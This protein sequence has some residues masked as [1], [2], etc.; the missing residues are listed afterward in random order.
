MVRGERQGTLLGRGRGH[1]PSPAQLLRAPRLGGARPRAPR[2]LQGQA[3]HQRSPK[4]LLSLSPGLSQ[5]SD[6]GK[7]QLQPARPP[8]PFCHRL[9]AA[10]SPAGLGAEAAASQAGPGLQHCPSGC[11]VAQ[12]GTR[13]CR[14]AAG[15]S[16]TRSQPRRA[17]SWEHGVRLRGRGGFQD[18]PLCFLSAQAGCGAPD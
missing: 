14:D 11:C 13:P 6:D 8:V 3:K 12:S 1:Q 9:L 18:S 2:V 10:L 7:P 15:A 4:L 17:S 5:S 16:R